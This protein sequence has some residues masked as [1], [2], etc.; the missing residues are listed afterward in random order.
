MHRY[1]TLH[2]AFASIISALAQNP[3]EEALVY[4][5]LIYETFNRPYVYRAIERWVLFPLGLSKTLGPMQ[6]KAISRQS[7]QITV[8]EGAK[9]LL[10]A[11]RRSFPI[12]EQS[13]SH[14]WKGE[15][16][17]KRQYVQAEAI[18]EATR[19]YN[20][21]SDYANEIESVYGVLVKELYPA[22]AQA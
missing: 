17:G 15:E 22:A 9:K 21:R 14:W 6:V 2:A 10:D 3:A 8:T 12:A 5:V 13:V 16:A 19:A 7:D 11:F 4:A 18:R 1:R 20:I